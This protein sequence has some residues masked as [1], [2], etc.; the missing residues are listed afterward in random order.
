MMVHSTVIGH[1]VNMLFL[2][3]N[4]PTQT[5]STSS[6]GRSVVTMFPSC[7]ISEIKRYIGRK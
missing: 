4:C 2:R 7:I 6:Y 5:T 1:I 3:I